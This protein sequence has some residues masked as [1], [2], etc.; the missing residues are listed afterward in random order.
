MDNIMSQM[1]GEI[2]QILKLSKW[3]PDLFNL[4]EAM[5]WHYKAEFM[6]AMTQ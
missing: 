1:M 6:Q 2:S 5:T 4:T 3:N